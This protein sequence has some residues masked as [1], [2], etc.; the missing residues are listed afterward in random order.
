MPTP[1]RGPQ[2]PP[3]EKRAAISLPHAIARSRALRLDGR[4]TR[5]RAKQHRT[6]RR[7]S[8]STLPRPSRPKG[9]PLAA[10]AAVHF[11]SP[12][13]P[14]SGSS[15]ACFRSASAFGRCCSSSKNIGHP[16]ARMAPSP[17]TSVA[18]AASF[19]VGCSA[20]AVSATMD[21]V[22]LQETPRQRD[23]VPLRTTMPLRHT[24]PQWDAML[25][26]DI[27]PLHGVGYDGQHAAC[28]AR[29]AT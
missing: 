24:V 2:K 5:E 3:L 18:R 21:T 12:R 11:S 19:D 20:S 22:P 13:A 16:W 23:T 4:A 6:L 25:L 14:F 7:F 28:S 1:A 8:P 29:R 10:S 17:A 27:V 26:R 15:S 9:A